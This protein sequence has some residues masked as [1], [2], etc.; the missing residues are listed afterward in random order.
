MPHIHLIFPF[1]PREQFDN[2]CSILLGFKQSPFNIKFANVE[3]TH[4][5]GKQ[6]VYLVC[7]EDSKAL[8]VS[9]QQRI[10]N[11]LCESLRRGN[12]KQ[13]SSK[14]KKKKK[15]K[16]RKKCKIKTN[17]SEDVQKVCLEQDKRNID[18]NPHLSIGQMNENEF[19]TVKQ[20]LSQS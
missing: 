7:D 8:L 17:E 12:G 13:L 9:L 10:M 3:R 5:T 20:M 6:Y 15:H 1:L 11:I 14:T 2:I 4:G 16:S 19:K 18:F